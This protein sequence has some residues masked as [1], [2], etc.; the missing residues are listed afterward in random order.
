MANPAAFT[1]Q[2][3]VLQA[4]PDSEDYCRQIGLPVHRRVV[5]KI[6]EVIACWQLD[7]AER[8]E[9]AR[10]GK[11]FLSM[12]GMTCPP[13]LVAAEFPEPIGITD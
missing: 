11:V 6:P 1:E 3:A 13:H 5:G 7:D 4:P 8:A 2:N 12:V 9:V 10:T